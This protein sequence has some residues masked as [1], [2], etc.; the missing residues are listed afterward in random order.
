MHKNSVRGFDSP[1]CPPPWLRAYF[2]L[3]AR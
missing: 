2:N 1:V 3:H